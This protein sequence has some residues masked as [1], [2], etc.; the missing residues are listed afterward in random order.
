MVVVLLL[1]LL[2][3]S[4]VVCSGSIFIPSVGILCRHNATEHE[5]TGWIVVM[6]L[7]KVF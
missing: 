2:L 6:K 4:V 3:S 5:I 1:S 7:E